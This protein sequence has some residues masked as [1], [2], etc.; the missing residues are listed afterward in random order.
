MIPDGLQPSS[1]LLFPVGTAWTRILHSWRWCGVPACVSAKV[2]VI[3]KKQ[4]N[5]NF[6]HNAASQKNKGRLR[7]ASH[8]KSQQNA[9]AHLNIPLVIAYVDFVSSL[10]KTNEKKCACKVY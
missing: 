8:T 6:K 1:L 5:R 7:N 10:F 9:L 3:S 2:M 4:H